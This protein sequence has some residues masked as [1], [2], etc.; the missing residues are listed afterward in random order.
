MK[1]Y[2]KFMFVVLLLTVTSKSY[3]QSF[4]AKA[5]LNLSK[6]YSQD[7]GE[8][9]EGLK[10]NPGFH[11]GGMVEF[12]VTEMFSF[13]TG[14]IFSTKGAK[15]YE[16]DRSDDYVYDGRVNLSYLNVPVNAKVN[17]NVG[18]IKI[19]GTAGP[20]VGYG[21]IGKSKSKET[22]RGRTTK[23]SYDIE[24]GSDNEIK[25]FDLGVAA[26][27]GVEINSIIVGVNYDLGL[28]NL[29]REAQGGYILKNRVF[30]LS[31]GYRFG[32]R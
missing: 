4:S 32:Q 22:S 17:F 14:L 3:S 13:E 29:S 10:I 26:G 6:F 19:F 11:I 25:R 7:Y 23:E 1:V 2:F 9:V 18:G 16:A 28:L 27:I 15:Y 8:E 24:W 31:V 12:P 20:T 30:G 5:G 21:I